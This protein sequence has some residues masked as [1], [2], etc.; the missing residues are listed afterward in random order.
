[1]VAEFIDMIKKHTDIH[2]VTCHEAM[3]GEDFGYFLKEIPG[4]MFWLGAGSEYGLHS[5]KLSPTKLV[6]KPA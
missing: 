4:F 1:M 2:F 6:L 5:T 3:T